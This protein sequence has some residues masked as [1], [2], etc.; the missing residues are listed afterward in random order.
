MSNFI[1]V[2]PLKKG[3]RIA[4]SIAANDLTVEADGLYVGEVGQIIHAILHAKDNLQKLITTLQSSSSKVT[5]STET[6]NEIITD[7]NEQILSITDGVKQLIADSDQNAACIKQASYALSTVTDNSQKTAELANKIA[8]YTKSVKDAAENGRTSVDSIVTAINDLA[9]NSKNVS[10]EVLGLE[11]Q[12][13]KITEIVNIISQISEQ[14][15]LLALNAAIEAARAGEA[16]RGFSVVAEEIRKLAEDTKVSLDDIG[17]LILEMKAKTGNVVSV[18]A[19]TEEKV[20]LGVSKSNVVK[21]SINEIIVSMENTFGMI[22][23]IT[24]G[25]TEQAAALEQMTATIDDINATVEAGLEVSN[26]ISSKLSSQEGLFR[27]I[28][29]T[30]NELVNLAEGMDDLTKVFKVNKN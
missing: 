23:D 7:A 10:S 2:K 1:I 15:N 21:S 19:V 25:V 14:T 16:G 29:T 9:S 30:S 4:D 27:K 11:E 26:K 24:N 13:N 28:S 20:N 12:S 22:T 3:K 5:L 17:K 8:D 6:L 18:V